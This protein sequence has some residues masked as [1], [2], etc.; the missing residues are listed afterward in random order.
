MIF[1]CLAAAA[2]LAAAADNPEAPK[3]ERGPFMQMTKRHA[4]GCP[5]GTHPVDGSSSPRCVMDRPQDGVGVDDAPPAASAELPPVRYEGTRTADL[6]VELPSGWHK[7]DAWSDEVPTLSAEHDPRGD[8]K[9]VTLMVSR[10]APGQPDYAP[11][12]AAVAVEK[13]ARGARELPR[14]RVAGRPARETV[15]EGESRSVYVDAGEGAYFLFVYSASGAD[16]KTY[17]R[18]FSRL[19]SSARFIK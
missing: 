6:S 1:A 9:P 14:R 19:L 11:L 4:L 13:E 8:G 16:F 5:P 18:A 12:A 15:V 2:W 17:E 10:V 3:P 7:T